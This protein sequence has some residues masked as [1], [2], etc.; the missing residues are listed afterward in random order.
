MNYSGKNDKTERYE[1]QA[2][3]GEGKLFVGVF[4]L[5]KIGMF[6]TVNY[7]VLQFAA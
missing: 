6:R 5:L 7:F 2:R 4:F 3:T 1:L